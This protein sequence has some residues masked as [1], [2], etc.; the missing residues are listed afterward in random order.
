MTRREWAREEIVDLVT[1]TVRP[2]MDVFSGQLNEALGMLKQDQAFKQGQQEQRE[3]WEKRLFAVLGL[4][5]T[6]VGAA[7][8]RIFHVL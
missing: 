5:T 4:L 3:K 2:M 6:G 8:L 1:V 7:L